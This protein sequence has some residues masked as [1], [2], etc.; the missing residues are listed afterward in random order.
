MSENTLTIDEK[1]EAEAKD[2]SKLWT[3]DPYEGR[4]KKEK[5]QV[6][7]QSDVEMKI[8]QA[9]MNCDQND[10][11]LQRLPMIAIYDTLK[12]E[13]DKR[14]KVDKLKQLELIDKLVSKN[15]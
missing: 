10:P 13:M 3:T 8:A 6:E 1:L 2:A 11:N 14:Y 12:K 7:S 9:L 5:I 15:D 4:L